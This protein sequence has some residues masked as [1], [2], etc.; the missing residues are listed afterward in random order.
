MKWLII[1]AK[2]VIALLNSPTFLIII[3]R[4]VKAAYFNYYLMLPLG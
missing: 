4:T 1:L 2:R 3:I